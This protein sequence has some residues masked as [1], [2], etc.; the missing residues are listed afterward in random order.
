MRLP[1]IGK[2]AQVVLAIS[3]LTLTIL[4]LPSGGSQGG[5]VLMGLGMVLGAAIL[6]GSL[7]YALYAKAWRVLGI[8]A[9]V[10]ALGLLAWW[11]WGSHWDLQAPTVGTVGSFFR[12]YWLWLLIAL[13]A[14]YGLVGL[15][16]DKWKKA[17][18]LF[19]YFITILFVVSVLWSW[20]ASPSTTPTKAEE[21]RLPT[22]AVPVTERPSFIVPAHGEQYV[23]IPVGK[24][25][26]WEGAV[27]TRY[28]YT[29][30]SGCPKEGCLVGVFFTNSGNEPVTVT[31]AYNK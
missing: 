11:V 28:N 27:G 26:H 3:I 25:I 8:A 19:L 29:H 30:Q 16:P 31:L 20:V 7:V 24:S 17:G 18:T 12:K 10:A 5:G 9:G 13:V 14:A 23:P 15:L 4:L 1:H 2:R 6:V 21:F 22:V